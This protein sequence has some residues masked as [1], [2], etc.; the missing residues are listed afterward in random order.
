MITFDHV[1]FSYPEVALPALHDV[2][3]TLLESAFTL[4][5]GPSG[6]GKT[7]L[8][9]CLNGL[10]PH[11][12]GGVLAGQIRVGDLDP[13]ALGPEV[14]CRHVGFVFQDPETQCVMD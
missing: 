5:S 11:F 6:A 2:N 9:R 13:V 4:I 7:T 14:M 1:S 3:L 12:S 8:L 10:V